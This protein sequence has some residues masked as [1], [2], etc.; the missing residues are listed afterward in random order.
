MKNI[1][2]ALTIICCVCAFTARAQNTPAPADAN[3]SADTAAG[4]PT[5][6]AQSNDT[7]SNDSDTAAAAGAAAKTVQS[8]ADSLDDFDS[9]DDLE[10][11]DTPPDSAAAAQKLGIVKREHDYKRQVKLAIV[12][13][14]LIAAALATSQSWNPR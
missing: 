7:V 9:D 11:A 3:T 2:I 13:M 6:A 5:D 8:N 1:I 14:I 12:M 10:I 4:A